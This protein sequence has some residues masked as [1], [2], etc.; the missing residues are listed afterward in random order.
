MQLDLEELAE[1]DF[2]RFWVGRG[3]WK[4]KL[5]LYWGYMGIME[6]RMETTTLCQVL[7]KRQNS[8]LIDTGQYHYEME[9]AF[10]QLC[11]FR[12]LKTSCH[13]HTQAPFQFLPLPFP[14]PRPP[15]GI[16]PHKPGSH[17]CAWFYAF[18]YALSSTVPTK[19]IF[20]CR[21]VAGIPKP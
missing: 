14:P 4:M 11:R 6:K 9:L 3:A 17:C 12:M 13:Q 18:S 7:G 19:A 10:T 1:S 21:L 16:G 5:G 2:A 20:F 8:S 15:R